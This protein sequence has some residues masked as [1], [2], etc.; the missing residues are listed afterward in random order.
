M[1]LA[2]RGAGA[3]LC[4]AILPALAAV[5]ARADTVTL[6]NG[7]VMEGLIVREDASELELDLGAGSVVLFKSD[8][9]SVAR[10]TGKAK[11]EL[12]NQRRE[13]AFASGRGVPD[14]A[15]EVFAR[16]QEL[17]KLGEKDS[18]ARAG[19]ETAAARIAELEKKIPESKKSRQE[20]IDWLVSVPVANRGP[21]FVNTSNKVSELGREIEAEEEE[22]AQL[23]A[24][25]PDALLAAKAYQEGLSEFK[26][27][28]ASDP[29]LSR[30]RPPTSEEAPF[31]DWVSRSLAKMQSDASAA[32]ASSKAKDGPVVVEALVNGKA[33]VQLVVDVG[34]SLVML[35]R[36]AAALAGVQPSAGRAPVSVKGSDGRPWTGDP[37]ILASV[38]VG[39]KAVEQVPA[40]LLPSYE[41]GFDGVVGRSF[42]KRFDF[43]VHGGEL[44]LSERSAP[45]AE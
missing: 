41:A 22:L 12:E 9:A 10:S 33:K 15:S 35:T 6:S 24:K 3:L 20:D 31:F 44:I 13:A 42:L 36:G 21:G 8:I 38:E 43:R 32:G 25:A 34:A 18:E 39:G 30:K 4:L 28:A 19:Q 11:E 37:V 26:L 14:S 2:H 17:R 29:V 7:S 16:F 5:P 45:S 27:F 1:A 23:R 40:A